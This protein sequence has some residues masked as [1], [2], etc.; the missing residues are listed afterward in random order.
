V[1][2]PVAFV[3][4]NNVFH[5]CCHFWSPHACTSSPPQTPRPGNPT[6]HS[7]NKKHSLNEPLSSLWRTWDLSCI[8][9]NHS[10][11]I[12]SG[13]TRMAGLAGW[14]ASHA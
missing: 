1:I 14:H 2:H 8:T 11:P 13:T 3:A 5:H 9:P 12:I 10:V 7:R 4:G 6:E